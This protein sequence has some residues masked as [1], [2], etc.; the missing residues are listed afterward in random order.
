MTMKKMEPLIKQSMATKAELISQ[1]K[2]QGVRGKL[3][4]MSKSQL[5]E[6]TREQK[7]SGSLELESDDDERV[8]GAGKRPP[9]NYQAFVAKHLKENGGD[10]KAA[11]AAFMSP[12]FSLRC[13]ATNAW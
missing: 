7:G 13:L 11:A 9:S 4:K 3:S 10:M 2:T 5:L 12:P 6:L 1:L 8:A